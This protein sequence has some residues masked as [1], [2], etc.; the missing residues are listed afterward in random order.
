M[1]NE[2]VLVTGASGFIA[3]HCAAQL[4]EKGYRVRGSLRSLTREAELRATIAKLAEAG[5]RLS[6]IEADLLNDTNWDDAMNGCGYVLHV[7]SPFPLGEP[8]DENDLIRPAV[9][10][11]LRVLRAA[12][13]AG[14]G[15]VVQ[16][17]SVAAI[18]YGQKPGRVLDENDWSDVN[19]NIGAYAKS[20]TLAERAAWDFVNGSENRTK[21]ELAVINPGLVLGPVPDRHAR[22]SAEIVYQIM[23][24]QIGTARMHFTAVDVRDVASAHLA[25]MIAPEAAGQ[26]F[27]CANASFWMKDAAIILKKHFGDRYPIRT[28]EFPSWMVRLLGMIDPT[29]RLTIPMLD[30]KDDL[31]D[32]KMKR[33]LGLKFHTLE[34][35]I[36]SMGESLIANGLL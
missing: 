4:L 19:A 27:I 26:R 22:S 21:L 3:I 34:E 30:K 16:T 32:A 5:D 14:V 7:A 15:R 23:K 18:A 10:G 33:V 9:E 20:K 13:R 31:S 17:S 29:I 2:T 35:M 36:V 11:T 8:Q 24:G 12:S 6:F 1:P 28:L 25:A